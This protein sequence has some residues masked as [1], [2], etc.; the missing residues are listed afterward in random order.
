MHSVYLLASCMCLL[1]Y[2]S[3][4]FSL[5]LVTDNIVA[6]GDDDGTLKVVAVLMSSH[7]VHLASHLASH[8]PVDKLQP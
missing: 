7:I 4:I 6:A 8:L 3:A 1:L 2:R 5:L